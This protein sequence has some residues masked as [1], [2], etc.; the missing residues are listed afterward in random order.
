MSTSRSGHLVLISTVLS[1]DTSLESDST[2]Q[3]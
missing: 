2:A 1:S 3:K